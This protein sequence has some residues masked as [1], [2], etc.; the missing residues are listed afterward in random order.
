MYIYVY[1][2]R[3]DFE[4]FSIGDRA[5]CRHIL[6]AHK[7][8][9]SSPTKKKEKLIM[10]RSESNQMRLIIYIYIYICICI[11]RHILQAHKSDFW[12]VFC[13]R[14]I[15]IKS[16]T[17]ISILLSR[18]FLKETELTFETCSCCGCGVV[19]ETDLNQIGRSYD[20]G[21]LRL[22]GSLKL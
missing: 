18:Y 9:T 4:T 3:T 10:M 2:S 12:D 15:S 7:S 13:R 11:F 1:T 5:I 14:L 20:M 21:W 8:V 6:Q 16:A 22:V 19:P 17:P